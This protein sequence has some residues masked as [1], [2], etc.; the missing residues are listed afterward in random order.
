MARPPPYLENSIKIIIF[1]LKP[2]LTKF[3]Q[4]HKDLT[5][6]IKFSQL[7]S[8]QPSLPVFHRYQVF[9]QVYQVFTVTKFSTKFTKFSTKFTNFHRYEHNE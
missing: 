1:F 5:K 8:F 2:S 6:F 4:L 7:P 3:S 9:N